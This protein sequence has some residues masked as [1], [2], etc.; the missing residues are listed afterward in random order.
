[1]ASRRLARQGVRCPYRHDGACARALRRHGGGGLGGV[2]AS[3]TSSACRGAIGRRSVR[4]PAACAV[5]SGRGSVVVAGHGARVAGRLQALWRAIEW[6]RRGAPADGGDQR[7]GERR[8]PSDAPRAA[9]RDGASRSWR[10]P[11]PAGAPRNRP[12][13]A[14]ASR[15]APCRPIS[16]PPSRR[17][18]RARAARHAGAPGDARS[19]PDDEHDP[20]A[21]RPPCRAAAEQARGDGQRGSAAA[22]TPACSRPCSRISA[23]RARSSRCGRARSSPSTSSSRRPASR[24]R[25]SSASPTTSRAR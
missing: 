19:D 5:A 6:R 1:M 10:R 7:A 18:R 23:S 14:S 21:A 24:R 8:Q 4:A 20:A 13:T 12:R 16:S 9:A 15:A 22:R 11:R 2:V 3:F 25:A 17:P